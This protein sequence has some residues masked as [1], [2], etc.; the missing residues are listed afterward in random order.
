MKQLFR[1]GIPSLDRLL[2]HRESSPQPTNPQVDDFGVELADETA[3]TSF[4]LIGQDGTGK[5][6]LALHLTSRYLADCHPE[7]GGCGTKVLYVSTDLTFSKAE[8]IWN[9]FDLGNPKGRKNPFDEAYS[10][11]APSKLD[12]KQV[13]VGDAQDLAHYLRSPLPP[14]VAFVDLAEASVGDDW[15]FLNRTLAGLD[16]AALPRHLLVIDAIEGFETLVGERDAYGEKHSRRSRIAQVMRLAARRCHVVFI[17]EEAEEGVRQPEEFVTDVVIRLRKVEINRYSRR[18]VEIEKVRGQAHARGHHSFTMRKGEGST[19]GR[20]DLHYQKY[21]ENCDDPEVLRESVRQSYV[22][23][24][25]SLHFQSRE[26]MERREAK[27]HEHNVASAGFGIRYLDEML[28]EGLAGRRGLPV[29]T[30][31]ALIGDLGTQ[32]TGLGHSFLAECFAG[33]GEKLL[34]ILRGDA[35]ATEATSPESQLCKDSASWSIDC[36]A[37]KYKNE[38]AELKKQD[39]LLARVLDDFG[40]AVLLTTTQDVDVRILARK[41]ADWSAS[42]IGGLHP[43]YRDKLQCLLSAALVTRIICRRLEFHDLPS[44]VLMHVVNQS[45]RRARQLLGGPQGVGNTGSTDR[46]NRLVRVVIDDFS[47]WKEIYPDIRDEPLFLPSLLFYLRREN[48]VTLIV[49]S[50]PG[51]PDIPVTDPF[52]SE[53]R[54]LVD[55]AIY[56]WRVPFYGESRIA[57]AAIPPLSSGYAVGV[58]ESAPRSVVRELKW[59][60]PEPRM[61]R[62][63]V[64][65]HFEL[66]AGMEEGKPQPVG[67]EV[68][69]YAET[70]EFARYIDEQNEVLRELFATTQGS[71]KVIRPIPPQDYNALRDSCAVFRDTRLDHT[72]ILQIDEFWSL[73]R[74]GGFRPQKPYLDAVT[75]RD[76]VADQTVDPFALFR[77]GLNDKWHPPEADVVKRRV[78]FFEENGYRLKDK[79]NGMALEEIDRVPFSWDFGFLLCNIQ[80]WI[81]CRN[82]EVRFWPGKSEKVRDV[83]DSLPKACG[84]GDNLAGFAYGDTPGVKSRPSWRRF[85]GACKVVAR[86]HSSGGSNYAAPFDLSM[87]TAESFSSLIVEI[88]ASESYKRLNKEQREFLSSRQ[89]DPPGRGQMKEVSFRLRRHLTEFYLTW[90]LLVDVLD[91]SRYADPRKPFDPVTRAADPN[92]IAVRHWYKTACAAQGAARPEVMVP[93]GLPGHFSARGDWFLTVTNASRSSWLADRALDFFSSRR[94]NFERMQLGL[95]LP[96]RNIA[97]G[98]KDYGDRLR[99]RLVSPCQAEGGGFDPGRIANVVYNDLCRIG[100]REDQEFFW[101]WRSAFRDYDLLARIWQKSLVRMIIAWND[102]RHERGDRW[103]SGFEMYD[104]ICHYLGAGDPP[105]PRNLREFMGDSGWQKDHPIS[106]DQFS[107]SW[108][109]FRELLDLLVGLFQQTM[110]EQ[111]DALDSLTVT[112]EGTPLQA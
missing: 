44:A 65:P 82:R 21:F 51:R 1:F 11:G 74:H 91:L 42:R 56:T 106:F 66:Y 27:G 96:T 15:A 93:V 4:C 110:D 89:W 5:S 10:T 30:V 9:K 19:T 37:R 31:T 12:L 40:V 100:E 76:G 97:K 46:N 41:F 55:H 54:A 48:V 38:A 16:D 33:L 84:R 95:G 86:A 83:W 98:H 26:V 77:P 32:K 101:L 6:V 104:R 22:L 108:S 25:P 111:T 18:T 80:P 20:G 69:M 52:D 28:V 35:V 105:D 13:K 62:P 72:L 79:E 34:G 58:P 45:V 59:S 17:V 112:G 88:W 78:D 57:I 61:R 68:R 50:H 49:D 73:R 107:E 53:L 92:A 39:L 63:E 90:L 64:D 8:Q 23:V 99:T 102:F 60:P 67:L 43:D 29:S 109:E 70:A 71:G 14:T 87:T 75:W 7:G 81:N 47:T 2:G 94:G 3:T 24:F 36:F 85:L 103:V